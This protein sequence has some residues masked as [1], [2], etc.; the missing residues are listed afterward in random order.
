MIRIRL[1]TNDDLLAIRRVNDA[2]F[3]TRDEADIVD[4]LRA[5]GHA[6]VSL[7]AE[8]GGRVVG[9]VLFS[10]MWIRTAGGSIDA[11]ALAPMAVV[12]EH[13]RQGIGGR[14]IHEGLRALRSRGE[15]IVIVVGHPAYYP[16]FGFASARAA[17]LASPFPAE[18]F[19]ALELVPGALDGVSGRVEY[20]K[21]FGL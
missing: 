11:V 20:P 1:E 4:A 10:R 5:E 3:G 15:T 9:H 18:A 2:A 7:V 17:A 12:P 13:Q 8:V 21:A 14:L 19:M 6:L 16:R